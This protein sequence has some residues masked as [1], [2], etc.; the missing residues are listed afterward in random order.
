M[1]LRVVFRRAARHDFDEAALW[2]DE[3]RAGLGAECMIE[4]DRAISMASNDP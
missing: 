1:S 4:I 2:Y 3:R